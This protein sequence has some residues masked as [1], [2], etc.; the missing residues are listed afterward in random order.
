MPQEDVLCL[1]FN[2]W[3]FQGFED[4]KI[5]LI[6]GIVT[7]LI[8]KRPLLTKAT[9][10]VRN[11]LH[12]IDLLKAA[13]KTGSLALTAYAGLHGLGASALAIPV[14]LNSLEGWVTDPSK[15][16]KE[17]VESAL[18]GAKDILKPGTEGKNVPEE[19]AAS[20]NLLMSSWKKQASTSSLYLLMI[21]TAVYQTRRSKPWKPCG[22]FSS[23]PGR[24]SWLLPMKR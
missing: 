7:G 9:D 6:E 23:L 21:S 10:A 13:K 17:N 11:I 2:G 15:L 8:E 5:A 12:R 22:S 19:I 16:I 18:S 24:R 20:E 14:L 4:A 3:R 1:K